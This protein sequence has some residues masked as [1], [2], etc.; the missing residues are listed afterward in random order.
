MN[1]GGIAS[2][3]VVFGASWNALPDC[4]PDEEA[5][6]ARGIARGAGHGSYVLARATREAM[7]GS[8]KGKLPP[9]TRFAGQLLASVVGAGN[10]VYL[11]ALDDSVANPARTTTLMFIGA[12]GA[13]GYVAVIVVNG[14]PVLE[15]IGTQ[16]EIDH[17]GRDFA[18]R[19]RDGAALLLEIGAAPAFDELAELAPSSV[20]LVPGLPMSADWASKTTGVQRAGLSQ[21]QMGL[22][23]I[24]GLLAIGLTGVVAGKVYTKRQLLEAATAAAQ[25]EARQSAESLRQLQAAAI[26]GQGAS[27]ALP[28]GQAAYEWAKGYPLSREGFAVAKIAFTD[29]GTTVRYMRT[30]PLKTFAQFMATTDGGTPTFEVGKREEATV[31]YPALSWAKLPRIDLDKPANAAAV[32]LELASLDQLAHVAGVKMTFSTPSPALN[33]EQLARVDAAALRQ[34]GRKTGTW[35]ATG[36]VD[37][38]LDFLKRLPAGACSLSAVEFTV[39]QDGKGLPAD[40]FT[41]SGRYLVGWD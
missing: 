2:L 8:I 19:L 27:A 37:L 36:P 24:A 13:D 31:Q 28:S 26:T 39:G 20:V 25:Q 21:W 32:M 4:E 5:R 40:V 23:L 3:A 6:T 41:A 1:A 16:A 14:V 15:S 29:K 7:V 10:V 11:N 38:Y 18:H 34:L 22:V 30:N 33:P 9:G 35:S 17:V 12:H